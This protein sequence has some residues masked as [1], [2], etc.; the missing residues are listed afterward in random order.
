M[1]VHVKHA[2]REV[3]NKVG[4]TTAVYFERILKDGM[5][6]GVAWGKTLEV[7][8]ENLKENK[9]IK[10]LQ[11]VTLLGGAGGISSQVHANILSQEILNKY[12]G[13]GYFLYAPTV[14]DSKELLEALIANTETSKVLE[15]A[16]NVDV[17]L[18]GIGG[19]I[20]VSTVL[21]TGYFNEKQIEALKKCGA[22]GDI[23]SRFFDEDGKAC[24][25]DINER[26]VGITLDDLKKIKK[27]I[28]I[29]GGK[30]KV[31]SIRGVLNGR[32]VDVLIT[33]LYVAYCLLRR[34]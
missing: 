33:D 15:L 26:I 8:V 18:V 22:V 29:A 28:A 5:K 16:K 27:V 2:D 1:V 9:S 6:I 19:P 34:A 7:M 32:Y 4:K 13:K 30:N 31:K 25:L 21:E 14:V 3:A 24:N 17:A 23:C 10:D 11:I 12:D 20:E